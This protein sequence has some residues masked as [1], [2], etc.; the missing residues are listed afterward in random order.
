MRVAKPLLVGRATDPEPDVA[1]VGKPADCT[2]HPTTAVK[3]VVLADSALNY[4]VR[5]EA[6]LYATAVVPDYWVLDLDGRQLHVFR[7][8]RS[9]PDSGT[10]YRTHQTFGPAD[11]VAPRAAPNCPVRVADRL[12]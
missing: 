3:V 6:E 5:D 12:P 7:D 8:P 4:G 2:S 9:I 10:A 1:I 11:S